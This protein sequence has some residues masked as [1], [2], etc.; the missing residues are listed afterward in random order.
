MVEKAC[1][2]ASIRPALFTPSCK[3][4]SLQA[5]YN[6][7]VCWSFAPLFHPSCKFITKAPSIMASKSSSSATMT[8]GQGFTIFEDAPVADETVASK[9][10]GPRPAVKIGVPDGFTEISKP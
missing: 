5:E 8:V 3:F 7:D 2:S 1:G 4:A 9:K 6:G 10:A